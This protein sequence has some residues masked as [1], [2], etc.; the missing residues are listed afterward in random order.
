MQKTVLIWHKKRT[1]NEPISNVNLKDFIPLSAPFDEATTRWLAILQPREAFGVRAARRRFSAWQRLSQTE[2]KEIKPKSNRYRPKFLSTG[3][4]P[5]CPICPISR[6]YLT[7]YVTRNTSS[8]FHPSFASVAR[9]LWTNFCKFANLRLIYEPGKHRP[10][11]FG[12]HPRHRRPT[13]QR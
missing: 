5:I 3:G 13:C 10:C 6:T 9:H 8:P 7:Q 12:F 1:Q 4:R 2:I 11:A